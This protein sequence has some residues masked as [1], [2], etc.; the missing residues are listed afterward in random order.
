MICQDIEKEVRKKVDDAVAQAKVSKWLW[1]R[2]K[3]Y[4]AMLFDIIMVLF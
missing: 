2:H 4:Y 3:F 1:T